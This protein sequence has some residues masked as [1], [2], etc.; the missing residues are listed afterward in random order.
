M[1]KRYSIGKEEQ[2]RRARLV[3]PYFQYLNFKESSFLVD[4]ENI[5]VK[6]GISQSKTAVH[7]M[8]LHLLS[9]KYWN[10]DISSMATVKS[11]S[12]ELQELWT[13]FHE[14]TELLAK[15]YRL[16]NFPH[17]IKEFILTGRFG[18]ALIINQ[19][20]STE[21]SYTITLP[22]SVKKKDFNKVWAYIEKSNTVNPMKRSYARRYSD[23]VMKKYELVEEIMRKNIDQNGIYLLV[24][25]EMFGHLSLDE[26][27]K[28]KNLDKYKKSRLTKLAKNLFSLVSDLD[29]AER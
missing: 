27:G 29:E 14:D 19:I 1:G 15:K 28:I 23:E 12:P 4:V 7:N 2:E 6:Y 5:R 13:E 21:D 22:R 16:S 17:L 11:Y 18:D 25:K 9:Q 3:A 26:E 24:K 10:R 8:P 20:V